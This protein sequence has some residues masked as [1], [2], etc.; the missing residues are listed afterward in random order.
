MFGISETMCQ[1]TCPIPARPVQN[2]TVPGVIG[3]RSLSEETG[4]IDSLKQRG[5]TGLL[6][7]VQVVLCQFVL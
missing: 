4:N 5:R 1:L 2:Q 3:V 6:E 7:K